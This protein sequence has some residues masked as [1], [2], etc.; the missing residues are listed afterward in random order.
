ML[1]TNFCSST[2]C[3]AAVVT[4][5]HGLGETGLLSALLVQYTSLFPL[6]FYLQKARD[7][8][9]EQYADIPWNNNNVMA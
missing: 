4:F 3:G 1:Q 7:I 5:F 6:L 2:F 9:D 8:T